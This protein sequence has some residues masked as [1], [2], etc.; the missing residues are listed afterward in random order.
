MVT[1]Q[2]LPAIIILLADNLKD[3]L[4]EALA[5]DTIEAARKKL[6]KALATANMI[7][8]VAGDAQRSTET[9]A[10]SDQDGYTMDSA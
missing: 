6:T 5:A 8:K 10:V 9:G 1:L 7:D 2:G 4:Q 3:E